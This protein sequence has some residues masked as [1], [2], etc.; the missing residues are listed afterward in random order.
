M[1][2]AAGPGLHWLPIQRV[3]PPPGEPA[4]DSTADPLAEET[5]DPTAAEGSP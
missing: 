3:P 5:A 4:A 2:T 1:L